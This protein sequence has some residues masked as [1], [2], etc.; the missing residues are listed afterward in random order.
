MQP[1]SDNPVILIV[2]DT[3]ENVDVLAGIL[4]EYYQVKIALNG[5]K[6]LRIAQSDPA[7]ALILLDVMMPEMDG[8][9]VCRQLQ[10]NE[11]TRRIP[12]I[13]VTAK[14]EDEDEAQ[15]LGL[16]AVDYIT[17][18]VSPAIVLARVRTQ[19][20]L[21]QSHRRLE[22]LS[23]K[24]GRYLSRQVYQSI[25]EG[26]QDARIGGNRKKLTVF[27]SDI[28]GFANQTE[29][30][31]SED[32]AFILNGYLNRMAEVVSKHGGTLDKFIG[33]AVL[34]FFGDP[35]TR[36][37]GEDAVACVRMALE[38]KETIA[39]LNRE[40]QAKGIRQG[41]EV[42][43]GISTGFSMVGNFGSDERMDYTIIGKQV[44]LANRLQ[45]AAQPGEILIGQETWLLVRD[46][47]LCV[48]KEP[49][50]VK[51]FERPIPTY[52]VMGAA[53]VPG[54]AL[55]ED[56]RSGFHLMLDPAQVE[57]AERVAVVEKL[58]AAIASLR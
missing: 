15:G 27:F 7:P 24:L 33:D 1:F 45:A 13:F 20:A 26:R 12:V 57:P 30:M 43:M 36:G 40:W 35:E 44:N 42:R 49:V 58:R 4:R 5:S 55:I 41:F 56:A 51:G 32:L 50:Q 39:E 3:P 25:F 28:V 37:V 19:L 53:L 54:T 18:P 22:D 6:A 14:S 17:K 31:E 21:T 38:M 46:M 23:L 8:Y 47:F 48:A 52:A 11:R 16:G 2:D 10:A 29:G 34:V 9:E